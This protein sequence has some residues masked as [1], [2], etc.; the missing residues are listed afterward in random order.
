MMLKKCRK[1]AE[2]LENDIEVT[3]NLNIIF[4]LIVIPFTSTTLTTYFQPKASHY[5]QQIT[6]L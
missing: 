1:I 6:L 2:A 3:P 4:I 5:K